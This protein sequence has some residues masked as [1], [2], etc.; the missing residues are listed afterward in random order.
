MKKLELKHIAPYLAYGLKLK[1]VN[2]TVLLRGINNNAAIGSL[3]LTYWINPKL[4]HLD[5]WQSG[6]VRHFVLYYSEVLQFKPILRPLSQLTQEIEHNG[7]K[8]VPFERFYEVVDCLDYLDIMLEDIHSNNSILHWSYE[9]IEK[10]LEWHF[11]I[12]GL[13]EQNLAIEKL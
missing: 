6:E 3:E 8:F 1:K 11:D 10:L 7:E 12:Y 13:I 5:I 9:I 2:Q 4:S